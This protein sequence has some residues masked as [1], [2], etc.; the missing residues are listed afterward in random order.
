MI[1]NRNR[2]GLINNTNNDI[3]D[4][5]IEI[6]NLQETLKNKKDYLN[7]LRND[8]IFN[9]IFYDSTKKHIEIKIITNCM[10]DKN[11][12]DPWTNV[13]VNNGI[14]SDIKHTI[15]YPEA[16]KFNSDLKELVLKYVND[17]ATLDDVSIV[18]E[19]ERLRKEI[20]SLN[21]EV[22]KLKN[23]DMLY[24]EDIKMFNGLSWWKK[25]RFKFK[26]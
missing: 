25:M 12:T 3:G 24:I 19:N 11:T 1:N 5:E 22:R 20:D 26:I 10:Q 21:E 18:C 13:I 15:K 17:G 2:I 6:K 8:N 7:Q 16:Y 9:S 14:Y 4:I 23:K